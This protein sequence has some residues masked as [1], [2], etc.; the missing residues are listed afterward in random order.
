MNYRTVRRGLR[1][2]EVPIR[3]EERVNGE[4]KLGLRVQIESAVAPWKLRFGKQG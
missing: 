2:V 1:M 3:F 4:S